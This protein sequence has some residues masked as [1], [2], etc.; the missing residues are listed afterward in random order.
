M[1][2][3]VAVD[4]KLLER[5]VLAVLA[6]AVQEIMVLAQTPRVVRLTLVEEVEVQAKEQAVRQLM[7]AKAAPVS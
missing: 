4:W 3:V 5:K 1:L 2:V 7:V 6:V